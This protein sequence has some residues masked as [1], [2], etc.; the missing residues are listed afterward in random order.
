MTLTHN[1]QPAD[2]LAFAVNLI[3]DSHTI[4]LVLPSPYLVSQKTFSSLDS[5]FTTTGSHTSYHL[6]LT[7]Q[8]VT[9]FRI[10]LS[11]KYF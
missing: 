7:Y 9:H 3:K 10:T 6:T 2:M 8:N 11:I 4:I 5:F 1:T